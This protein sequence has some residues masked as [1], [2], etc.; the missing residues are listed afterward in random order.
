M[1]LIKKA[2]LVMLVLLTA[3]G[4]LLCFPGSAKADEA[5]VITNDDVHIQVAENNVISVT[6]TMTLNFSEPRHGFYYYVQEKGTAWREYEGETL[7]TKYNNRVSNFNVQGYEFSLSRENY[8]DESYLAAQIG[9]ENTLVSG[10][11]TYVIT[12]TC[13]LGDNGEDAFDEFYRNIIMAAYD[14]TIENASFTIDMPKDFDESGVYFYL[15]GYESGSSDNVEWSKD[16]DTI[17]GHVT[18]PIT[19]GEYLTAQVWLP[20]GYFVGIIDPEAAWHTIVYVISG[21]CVLLALVLWLLL[22]RDNAVYPTV[23]FYPPEGMTPAEAG[24]VID[25]CV[26]NNDVVALILYWADKGYLDIVQAEKNEFSFVKKREPEGLKG[27]EK[28]MFDKLFDKGDIV[29]L[30]SLKYS[31]YTTMEATKTAVTN[32]YEGSKERR[33]FTKASKTARGWMGIITM[34]PVVVMLFRYLYL[35]AGFVM[36]AVVTA[37][38]AALIATPV[39]MLVRLLEK[40]RSTKPSRKAGMLITS[41]LLLLVAMVLYLAVMPEKTT[42]LVSAAATLA[43][44]SLTVIMR[45]RTEPG[46]KWYGQLLGFKNFIDKAEKDR[47]LTLVEQNPSYFYNVLPYAYVLGVTDKWAKNFENIGLQP[48]NWYH[49]YYGSPMFNTIMFTSL[50]THHMNGFQSAMAARPQSRSGGFGGSGG[51]SGGGF[52]GGGGFSGGGFGGGGAGGSW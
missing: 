31:F 49:G 19:G 12:Y 23:E 48:P 40:W 36:A 24:Y 33:V 16:G 47:I 4:L 3:L 11:Q 18:R 2:V 44:L 34:L 30:A 28:A 51:Y 37:A 14:N 35:D 17:S 38:G 20:E 9:S 50:M 46:N 25:G 26:D 13:N 52:G 7:P 42:A 5:Y 6:E 32:Y 27:Y 10:E 29:T 8:E 22:G 41:I 43:L 1:K 39:F 15:G 21:V 45:K